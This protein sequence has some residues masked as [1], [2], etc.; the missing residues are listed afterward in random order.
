[1]SNKV[2]SP[3]GPTRV[4]ITKF[5]TGP[6]SSVYASCPCTLRCKIL[7]LGKILVTIPSHSNVGIIRQYSIHL[8]GSREVY[9]VF[10]K[11]SFLFSS[12]FFM[13][14][15]SIWSVDSSVGLRPR[16]VLNTGHLLLQA[17]RIITYS[18]YAVDSRCHVGN[19][20]LSRVS[21]LGNIYKFN[22]S[23]HF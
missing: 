2:G 21:S 16:A 1:M 17:T 9:L 19:G 14:F 7:F 13:V 15:G 23:T 12:Y 6:D 8:Y 4:E 5:P 11:R 18:F 3:H 10:S 20:M 22:I